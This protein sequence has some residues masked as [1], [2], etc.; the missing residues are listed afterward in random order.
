MTTTDIPESELA[1]GSSPGFI[2]GQMVIYK[3]KHFWVD[4]MRYVVGKGW[5]YDLREI[6]KE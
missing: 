3:G 6:K 5:L 2:S 4:G 1:K